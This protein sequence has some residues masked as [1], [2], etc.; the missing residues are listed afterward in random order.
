V[1]RAQLAIL[2]AEVPIRSQEADRRG[3]DHS[4][5]RPPLGGRG[6]ERSASGVNEPPSV[7]REQRSRSE[8]AL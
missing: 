6:A 5:Y 8:S 4:G 1:L 7:G 2:R 3:A